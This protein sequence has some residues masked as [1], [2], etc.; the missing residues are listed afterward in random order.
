MVQ[1]FKVFPVVSSRHMALFRFTP[2][3]SAW[4]NPVKTNRLIN[5]PGHALCISLDQKIRKHD[6]T[7]LSDCYSS[8]TACVITPPAGEVP[9][10]AHLCSRASNDRQ[11]LAPGLQ[12]PNQECTKGSGPGC[13]TWTHSQAL[14]SERR[15][16]N[17][18]RISHSVVQLQITLP[19]KGDCKYGINKINTNL[20]Y[21]VF[22]T[23]LCHV[24]WATDVKPEV[25]SIYLKRWPGP[26]LWCRP[27]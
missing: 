12:S 25:L 18:V 13:W 20:F 14:S 19:D 10:C 4:K 7:Q 6:S 22:L 9:P 15:R 11:M 8:F 26:L 3:R 5:M 1:P 27:C 17:W 2:C 24:S 16:R 23:I 21:V